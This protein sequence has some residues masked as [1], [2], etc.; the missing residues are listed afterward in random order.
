MLCDVAYD[1][2]EDLAA[3]EKTNASYVSRVARL[4][5]LAPEIMEE[6]L[7]GK[8]PAHLTTKVLMAPFPFEWAGRRQ[9]FELG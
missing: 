9:H 3:T 7:E 1:T 8:Q 5:L 2:I 6:I 4:A